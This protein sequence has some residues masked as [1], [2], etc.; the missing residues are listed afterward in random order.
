M[1]GKYCEAYFLFTGIFVPE[2]ESLLLA[3]RQEMKSW[4]GP[5][6]AICNF[7]PRD[8]DGGLCLENPRWKKYIHIING[9]YIYLSKP[10]IGEVPW[11]PGVCAASNLHFKKAILRTVAWLARTRVFVRY[12]FRGRGFR[13]S[14]S[15]ETAVPAVAAAGGVNMY[16]YIYTHTYGICVIYITVDAR[17]S[18]LTPRLADHWLIIRRGRHCHSSSLQTRFTLGTLLGPSYSK[19]PERRPGRDSRSVHCI[20]FDS[21]F[22][23]LSRSTAIDDACRCLK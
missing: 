2:T 19:P 12:L 15:R 17:S 18:D 6:K 16:T 4:S 1:H 3:Y 14:G 9:I 10:G 20:I 21:S 23:P 5:R 7:E 13:E 22:V 11:V 8:R